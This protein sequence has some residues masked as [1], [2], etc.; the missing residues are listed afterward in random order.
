MM[1]LQFLPNE[2]LRNV[3]LSQV[4]VCTFR[5]LRQCGGLWSQRGTDAGVA[6]EAGACGFVLPSFGGF[7]FVTDVN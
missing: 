2:N 4:E 7:G 1:E 6:A 3:V 5:C